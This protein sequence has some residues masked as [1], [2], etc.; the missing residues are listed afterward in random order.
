MTELGILSHRLINQLL[1]L[2]KERR[3]GIIRAEHGPVKKQFVLRQG[4]LAFAESNA[5]GDHLARVMVSIN[6]LPKSSLAGIAAQ[7]K[8]KKTSDEAILS[9]C[10]VTQRDLEEGAREQALAVL[11]SLMTWDKG[12]VR[13]FSSEQ[14]IRRQLDLALPVPDLIVA[15]ARRAASKRP[16]PQAFSP[17]SG[18]LSPV[19]ENRENLLM[20][21][22]DRTEAFA[23]SLVTDESPPVEDLVS[24]LLQEHAK[25]EELIL[26]LLILGLVRKAGPPEEEARAE[27]DASAEVEGSIDQ[28]L[29]RSDS[30][31][32]Y[33]ILGVTPDASEA[34]IKEAY[35][36]M[37][38]QY[39]PDRF[40]A[41]EFS[42]AVRSKAQQ[43]FASV[44]D[45]YAR[46]ADKTSRSAYDRERATQG[47]LGGAASRGRAPADF[48][49]EN[50]AEVMYRVGHGFFAKG[51]FGKAAEKL[52]E[53][54][55]LKPDVAKYHY[56]L[57]ASQA[58]VAKTRKEAEQS[59][60]KAI[61]LDSTLAEAYL[62]LGKLYL[63]VGMSRRAETQ[64]REAQRLKPKDPEAA[65]LI[66]QIESGKDLSE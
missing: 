51:E 4:R 55:W 41:G 61:E 59:L 8:E 52:R 63:K 1:E 21:P 33:T 22:L 17:L 23:F 38:R 18:P 34:Q 28:L 39:H 35:Y 36:A 58:E 66:R 9:A 32:L 64:L 40:Q 20:L 25:P 6:L 16:I 26:R 30:G 7:M 45:A 13:V 46:L 19:S 37:A 27:T 44:T 57:G 31:D 50:M 48:D 29:Q 42:P 62:A 65:E 47:G 54:V 15:A 43:L 10:K 12:E 5:P 24:C 11:A 3:G 60:L 56:L 49:R 14:L 2:H 53:C